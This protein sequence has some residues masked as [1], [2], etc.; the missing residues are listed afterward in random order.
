MAKFVRWLG[1][2]CDKSVSRDLLTAA[3]WEGSQTDR[4]VVCEPLLKGKSLILSERRHVHV[5]LIPCMSKTLFRVGYL[6]DAMTVPTDDG[7]VEAKRR[8]AG[9]V[10]DMDRYIARWN[11]SRPSRH[12]EIVVDLFAVSAV[13]LRNNAPSWAVDSAYDIAEEMGVDVEIV[14]CV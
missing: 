8:K 3:M 5:G 12:G 6:G 7:T 14:Y 4:E 10:R 13:A 1:A 9:A 11:K 2:Y